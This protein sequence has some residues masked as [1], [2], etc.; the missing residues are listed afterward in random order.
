M[1]VVLRQ[2]IYANFIEKNIIPENGCV[3]L[4][5]RRNPRRNFFVLGNGEDSFIKLAK[6]NP[7][8]I[9]Y[10]KVKVYLREKKKKERGLGI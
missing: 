7:F 9:L 5:K 2:G 10:V 1:L 8:M 4:V 3:C 6:P